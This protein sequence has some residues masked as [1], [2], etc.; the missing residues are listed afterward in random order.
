MVAIYA[1]QRYRL[2]RT[3][4][5]GIRGG[6]TG[7]AWAF[8]LRAM[9]YNLLAAMTAT[10]AG[11]WAQM[12]LAETRINNSYFGDAKAFLQGSA[13]RVFVSYLLGLV[14]YLAVICV[15]GFMIWVAFDLSHV[16]GAMI[17]S[18]RNESEA[19]A[20]N[21]PD[22]IRFLSAYALFIIAFI[23][24]GIFAFCWYAAA[25]FRVL[26]EGLTFSDLTFRSTVGAGNYLR[27]WLGNILLVIVTFGFGLPIAVHRSL[28]FFADRL[29][30][31]G[32]IDVERLRQ[33]TL[34]KP[35]TGEGL[36][37]TF[38]PGFW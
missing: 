35:K 32:E 6:M 12:R 9:G 33:N 37:E 14:I 30:I 8:G 26:T 17:D 29:E 21:T 28:H 15:A 5:R 13:S 18:A 27:L 3:S 2:T 25:F 24:A 22:V 19:G 20:T 31:I 16:F 36:L 38:D 7:S 4:W 23:C 11:P 10:L 1:A 34:P